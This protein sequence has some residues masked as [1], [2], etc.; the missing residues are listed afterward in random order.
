METL[1]SKI[2][3]HINSIYKFFMAHINL[4]ILVIRGSINPTKW[5]NISKEQL[6]DAL[7]QGMHHCLHNIPS[8]LFG[9][10]PVC[11]DGF[12]DKG[13]ECDC[14]LPKVT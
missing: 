8:K 14:G 13:E 3:S 4:L 12:V 11:G 2:I 7:A 9:D 1:H 6:S 5:S 10:Q